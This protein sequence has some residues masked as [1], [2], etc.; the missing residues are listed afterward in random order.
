MNDEKE[1]LAGNIADSL[2]F[3]DDH[4]Q[5]VIIKGITEK[6]E[7]LGKKIKEKVNF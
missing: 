1:R 4:I 5:E 2:I 7:E 6:D 3:T